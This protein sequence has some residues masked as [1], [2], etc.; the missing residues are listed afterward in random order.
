M[1]PP[2]HDLAL[3]PSVAVLTASV[4]AVI[5]DRLTGALIALAVGLV[6]QLVAALL[7]PMVDALALRLRARVAPS[8]PPPPPQDTP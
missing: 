6:G 5:S 7:R 2:D 3:S 1:T 4:G 8:T